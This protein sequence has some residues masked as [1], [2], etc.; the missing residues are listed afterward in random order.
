MQEVVR[1]PPLLEDRLILIAASKPANNGCAAYHL[2]S[3]TD[4]FFSRLPKTR[5]H[6]KVA[7]IWWSS[8]QGT[9]L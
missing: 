9:I 7:F 8:N 2:L 1:R 5:R 3:V 4:N 6:I